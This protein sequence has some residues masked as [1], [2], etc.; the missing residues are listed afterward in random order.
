MARTPT[1]DTGDR[2]TYSV[3]ATVRPTDGVEVEAGVSVTGRVRDGESAGKAARRIEAFV[4]SR[5]TAKINELSKAN[6]PDSK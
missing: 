2:Y 4:E 5:L 6:R 3:T 1:L